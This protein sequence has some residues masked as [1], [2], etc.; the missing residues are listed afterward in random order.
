MVKKKRRARPRS[1]HGDGSGWT[2]FL[3]SSRHPRAK[4]ARTGTFSLA[5]AITRLVTFFWSDGPRVTERKR[6]RRPMARV[7]P[8]RYRRRERDRGF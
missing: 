6:G 1:R 4:A 3:I 8:H 7:H 2:W 5:G